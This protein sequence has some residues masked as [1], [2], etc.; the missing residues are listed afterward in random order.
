MNIPAIIVF[1][2]LESLSLACLVHLWH[3]PDRPLRKLLWSLAVLLPAM[4]PLLY[5][6]MY[7]LPPPDPTSRVAPSLNYAA[8]YYLDGHSQGHPDT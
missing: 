7:Q 3:Q 2:I 5:G 1:V 4:G 6:G 8:T